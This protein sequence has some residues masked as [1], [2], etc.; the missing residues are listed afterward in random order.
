M[1]C[2]VRLFEKEYCNKRTIPQLSEIII[3]ISRV[4]YFKSV[5]GLIFKMSCID[6]S[7]YYQRKKT[8]SF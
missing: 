7:V 5:G 6:F 3:H 1:D 8:P 4:F 2:V